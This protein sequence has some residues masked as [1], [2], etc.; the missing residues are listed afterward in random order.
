MDG[1]ALVCWTLDRSMKTAHTGHTVKKFTLCLEQGRREP[2]CW[3][4]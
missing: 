1:E 3:L 2:T 4:A